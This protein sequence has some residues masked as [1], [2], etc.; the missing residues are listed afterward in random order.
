M[1]IGYLNIDKDRKLFFSNPQD[2]S[3]TL[4]KIKQQ[5]K[6][7]DNASSVK[8]SQ[9]PRSTYSYKTNFSSIRTVKTPMTIG[10]SSVRSKMSSKW[11]LFKRNNRMNDHKS[12]DNTSSIKVPYPHLESF[13]QKHTQYRFGK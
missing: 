1:K 2:Q 9:G 5:N 10:Q 13:I 3:S 12:P 11:S 4:N 8:K 6:T 7:S